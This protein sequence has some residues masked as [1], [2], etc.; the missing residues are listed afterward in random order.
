MPDRGLREEYR[1]RMRNVWRLKRDPYY[2]FVY[3]LKCAVHFHYH[4]M[5]ERMTQR[6]RALVNSF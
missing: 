1:R 6:E 2:M 3:A 5:V 4:K